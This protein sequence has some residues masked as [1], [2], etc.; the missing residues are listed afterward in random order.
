MSR[1]EFVAYASDL[2]NEIPEADR[3]ALAKEWA[4]DLEEFKLDLD[5]DENHHGQD[6]ANQRAARELELVKSQLLNMVSPSP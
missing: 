6:G 1:D 3:P 5:N 2:Y 4:A